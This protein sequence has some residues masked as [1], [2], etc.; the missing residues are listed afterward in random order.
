MSFT[1]IASACASLN[2]DPADLSPLETTQVSMLITQIDGVIINYC[3]WHLLARDYTDKRYDGDGTAL[4]DLRVYPVNSVTGL[5][6]RDS[7]GTFTD[8]DP[9]TLE[10]LDG[11]LLQF[12]PAT[13]SGSTFTTGKNNIFISFNAGFTTAPSDLEY[14]ANYLIALHFNRIVNDAMGVQSLKNMG[15]EV[16]FS[17]L[18]LPIMVKRVLDRYQIPSIS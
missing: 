18:E 15:A 1:T 3:G 14:A 9:S 12:D 13:A 2:K 10:I 5:R 8:Y 11:G 17:D 6:M 7:G 16:V 4:L